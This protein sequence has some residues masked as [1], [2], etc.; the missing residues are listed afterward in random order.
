MVSKD[1]PACCS[2]W[3]H[4]ELG[5]VTFAFGIEPP[6]WVIGGVAGGCCRLGTTSEGPRRLGRTG[7]SVARPLPMEARSN[8]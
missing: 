6:G 2:F 8:Q 3:L 4:P 5:H 1:Y 7:Y